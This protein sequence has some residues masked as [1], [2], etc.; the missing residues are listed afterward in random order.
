MGNRSSGKMGFAIARAARE[1]GADVTLVAG[2]CDLDFPDVI[3]VRSTEDMRRAVTEHAAKSDV[4][5]MAAAPLDFRPKSVA[6]HKIKKQTAAMQIELEPTTDILKE[7][8]ASNNGRVLVGFAAETEDYVKNGLTK[9]KEKNL[10][11]IVVN[12]V[13]GPD[14]AFGNDTNRATLIDSSGKTEDVP[15]MSKDQL[16]DVILDRVVGL[17]GKSK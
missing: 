1:R 3:R 16:A 17:L 12:P 6:D 13:G 4:V 10:N 14:S 15:R 8:G 2:P 11:L 5:I 7:L 9:L